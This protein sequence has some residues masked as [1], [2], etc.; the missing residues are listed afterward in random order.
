MVKLI[1]F[2]MTPV[3]LGNCKI[4]RTDRDK[5]DQWPVK[6]SSFQPQRQF[7]R[8]S[9]VSFQF[10][11]AQVFIFQKQV[12]WKHW[13]N[14][15]DWFVWC[16]ARERLEKACLFCLLPSC[17]LLPDLHVPILPGFVITPQGCPFRGDN[18]SSWCLGPLDNSAVL[19]LF[20]YVVSSKIKSQVLT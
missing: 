3:W 18:M 14:G 5:I 10:S 4:D 7:F 12:V 6:F 15:F 9:R 16:W 1:F 11:S 19:S 2:N 8:F 20:S 13:F 17:G